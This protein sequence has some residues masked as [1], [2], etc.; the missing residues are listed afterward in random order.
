MLSQHAY[1]DRFID[2]AEEHNLTQLTLPGAV[3]WSAR[4]SES[5]IDLTYAIECY[6]WLCSLTVTT[7]GYT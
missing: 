3:T 1:D 6:G 4:G 2:I 5:T 7:L